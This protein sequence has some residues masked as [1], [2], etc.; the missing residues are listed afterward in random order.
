MS[1]H[2]PPEAAPQDPTDPDEPPPADFRELA[3]ELASSRQRGGPEAPDVEPIEAPDGLAER[4]AAGRRAQLTED[5]TEP[6]RTGTKTSEWKVTLATWAAGLLA[7]GVGLF[8]PGVPSEELREVLVWLAGLLV[9]GSGAA[10]TAGRVA[11]KRR[12]SEL[13]DPGGR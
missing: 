3:H 5:R 11:V 8:A 4:V 7:A 1:T 13:A 12:L 2:R 10:Y 6:A 9:G